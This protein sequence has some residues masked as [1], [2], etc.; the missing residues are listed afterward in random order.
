MVD[1]FN[2]RNL[3]CLR[4]RQRNGES[5]GE[6]MQWL[7]FGRRRRELDSRRRNQFRKPCM[8]SPRL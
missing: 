1:N 6:P 4:A 2:E 8:D 3:A 5:R 7:P